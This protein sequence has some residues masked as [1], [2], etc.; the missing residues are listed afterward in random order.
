MRIF[1]LDDIYIGIK[2][3]FNEA[4]F[5][6]DGMQNERFSFGFYERLGKVRDNKHRRD[7]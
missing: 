2:E 7:L 4:D 1:Y 3:K 6:F 5:S